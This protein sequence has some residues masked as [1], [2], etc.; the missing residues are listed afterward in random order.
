[1]FTDA[2]DYQLGACVMQEGKPVQCYSKKLN[3][4]T[5]IRAPAVTKNSPLVDLST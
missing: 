3:R 4:L 1:M 5:T 2:Y